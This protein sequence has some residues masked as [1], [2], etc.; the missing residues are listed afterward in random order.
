MMTSGS[1]GTNKFVRVPYHCIETNVSSL[2]TR[3]AIDSTDII[4]WG[5]PLTF[6]PSMVEFLLARFSGSTLLVVP[7]ITI[8]NPNELC[9][10]VIEDQVT[11][12]Q[13]VPSVFFRWNENQI[14]NILNNSSLRILAF[15]GEPF[16]MDILRYKRST[17]L[18][19]FN[20]YGVTEL[21]C[22]ATI[23][24]IV[25]ENVNDSVPIGTALE[26]TFVEVRN[27]SGLAISYGLGEICVGSTSRFCMINADQ[28]YDFI[29]TGDLG[30]INERGIFYKGRKNR[31]IKRLG[32]K[33]NLNHIEEIIFKETGL[34]SRLVFSNTCQKILA[35][36]LVKELK[37][38]IAKHKMLDKLRVKLLNIIEDKDFPDYIE[39][40]Y[41]FPLGAH[42]KVNDKLLEKCFV[43]NL[44]SV[45]EI[46]AP[47]H[48]FSKYLGYELEVL[49]R[50]KGH[51]LRELGASS[52]LITQF[53]SEMEVEFGAK[54][55]SELVELLLEGTIETCLNYLKNQPIGIKRKLSETD[56]ERSMLNYVK[57]EIIWK[58][59]LKACVDASP[60]AFEVMDHLF[61]A[62]GSFAHKFAILDENGKTYM[63]FELPQVVEAKP[64][65]SSSTNFIC[66]GCF[67][68]VMYC[69]SFDEKRIVWRYQTG[70]KIKSTPCFCM[71]STAITFGSY[72]EYLH[73]VLL[74]DGR[75]LWKTPVL[76]SICSDSLCHDGKIYTGTLKGNCYCVTEQRGELVWEYSA[77]NPI[78]SSPC[79]L[80]DSVIWADVTG[81]LHCLDF[82]GK[83]KWK[84]D[85]G[86]YV[87]SSLVRVGDKIYFGSHDMNLYEVSAESG[88]VTQKFLLQS[89]ISSTPFVYELDSE[90]YVFCTCNS[91][92]LS[93]VKVASG[94]ISTIFRFQS[95][96]FSSPC[97]FKDKI[98]IGCRDNYLHCL[99]L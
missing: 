47:E 3:F 42:G 66:V 32:H 96:T 63:V 36:I 83:V 72:D 7:E 57:T 55:S 44:G 1:T 80:T 19:I 29:K 22:W 70:D 56:I 69:M 60:I 53:L 52:I 26:E 48:M 4:F 13:I 68:G 37:S 67:D 74:K 30:E 76:G 91:G 25:D 65:V 15:G 99:K 75:S 89:E 14:Y 43:H 39:I 31:S 77:G 94:Y 81:T 5:T 93:R 82:A 87:F 64:C 92:Y 54:D 45:K 20:L 62:V 18:K 95:E 41:K 88:C 6:D 28:P 79:L 24:E 34:Q 27:D 58:Y 50:L 12:L 61:V 46:H 21:S 35:F 73:C 90:I 17:H 40:I 33:V 51:T 98:F 23:H 86:A 84:Y 10:A 97:V 71:N 11:F 8:L 49:D 59:D 78:F 38:N 2:R 9:Q 16:P 85:I